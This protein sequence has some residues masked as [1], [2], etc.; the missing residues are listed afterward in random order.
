MD[1]QERIPV[2][3]EIPD[4]Q[5][6]K[7]AYPVRDRIYVRSVK[8]LHQRLRRN[9]GFVFMALFFLSPGLQYQGHQAVLLDIGEQKF[10]I[11]GMTLWP[12]DFTIMAWIFVIGA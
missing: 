12:Q 5:P 8:G 7:D 9:M 2:K 6:G 4:R 10:N 1:Q 3:V 11:F